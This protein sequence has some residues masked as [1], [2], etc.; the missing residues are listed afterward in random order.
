MGK[1]DDS[2][3]PAELRKEKKKLL[4]VLVLLAKVYRKGAKTRAQK[5]AFAEVE[6][7]L[8]DLRRHC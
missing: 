5:S 7:T 1:K 6:S 4:K 3:R 2:P 8:K